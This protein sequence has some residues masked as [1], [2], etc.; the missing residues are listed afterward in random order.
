MTP[1]RMTL[2]ISWVHNKFTLH[3]ASCIAVPQLQQSQVVNDLLG[4][5]QE[6]SVVTGTE[7]C[8]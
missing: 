8:I 5:L 6:A 4:Y 3:I 1:R 7:I 2:S